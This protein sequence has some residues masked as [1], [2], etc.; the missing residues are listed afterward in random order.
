[1]PKQATKLSWSKPVPLHPRDLTVKY[2]RP[3]RAPGLVDRWVKSMSVKFGHGCSSPSDKWRISCSVYVTR[4]KAE[5]EGIF[6]DPDTYTLHLE[7]STPSRTISPSP[8][9]EKHH[10]VLE[11]YV[12]FN[13]ETLDHPSWASAGWTMQ[14][15]LQFRAPKSILAS[16]VVEL[17]SRE[18]GLLGVRI[19]S[20]ILKWATIASDDVLTSTSGFINPGLVAPSRST[21]ARNYRSRGGAGVLLRVGRNGVSDS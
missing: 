18:G 2:E 21:V 20:S 14:E 6:V 8:G 5:V 10:L 7:A 13:G 3:C 1:M 9:F 16:F 19:P 12:G 15:P 11:E 17:K 4:T